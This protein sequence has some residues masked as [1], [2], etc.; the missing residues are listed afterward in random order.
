MKREGDSPGDETET[1][2]YNRE[3]PVDILQR[4]LMIIIFKGSLFLVNKY[5]ICQLPPDFQKLVT[6]LES[7]PAFPSR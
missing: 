6:E 7:V 4:L 5:K 3:T 2:L 1:V